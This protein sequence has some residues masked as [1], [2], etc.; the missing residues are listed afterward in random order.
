MP[1]TLKNVTTSDSYTPA[2]TLEYMASIAASVLV[3]NAGV[4]VEFDESEDGRGVW[5]P[6]LFWPPFLGWFPRRCSGIR[7]KSAVGGK[8]AQVSCQLFNEDESSGVGQ[9]S[10]YDQTISPAGG[11]TPQA[12]STMTGRIDASGAIRA[13][14]G[15][16]CAHAGTGLYRIDYHAPFANSPTVTLAVNA[17]KQRTICYFGDDATGFYCQIFFPGGVDDDTSWSFTVT[18]TT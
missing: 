7:F 9:L 15:F 4:L 14:T 1:A 10:P 11:V 12:G 17:Q 3:A 13:G 8:P 16:D 18:P 5:G 6:E 2:A